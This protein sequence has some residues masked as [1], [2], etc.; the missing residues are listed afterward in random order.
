M[1]NES[2]QKLTPVLAIGAAA[3]AGSA[4]RRAVP[5]VDYSFSP[6]TVEAADKSGQFTYFKKSQSYLAR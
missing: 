2:R 3:F 5:K 6:P 1:N 4:A